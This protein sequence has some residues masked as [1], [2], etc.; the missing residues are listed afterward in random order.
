MIK[1]DRKRFSI[2]TILV[3]G[4]ILVQQFS[5]LSTKCFAAGDIDDDDVRIEIRSI[6]KTVTY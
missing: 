6:R 5:P 1:S 2:I 3:I 4:F